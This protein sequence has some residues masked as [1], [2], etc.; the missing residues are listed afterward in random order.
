MQ[1]VFSL[2]VLALAAIASSQAPANLYSPSRT[3]KDQG[4]SLVGWGSGT[5]AE[6]DETAYEGASSLRVSTRNYFQGGIMNYA[7]P[8]NLAGAFQDSNNLLMFTVRIADAS[9]TMGGG[10]G[11][12][13]DLGSSS[14][15]GGG[16]GGGAVGRAGGVS[17]GGDPT[18][19]T[20]PVKLDK[21]RVILT[22]SDSKKSEAYLPLSTSSADAKGWIRVGVPL[23]AIAG[24][25]STNQ[26]VKSVAVSANA[27]GSVYV[28]EIRILNDATPIYGELL[29][30]DMNIG[31][32][33]AVNLTASGQAGAS[34]LKYTWS[35]QS[36]DE[37]TFSFEGQN[38][39]YRF[40]KPGT[41]RVSVTISDTNGLKKPYTTGSAVI[42]VN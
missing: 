39:A 1:K 29:V 11:G 12:G 4:I 7:A 34:I 40:R 33:T 36:A 8:V 26:M 9:M 18:S 13:G 2:S 28:G 21:I 42:T 5:I 35:I 19:G 15:S 24:F 25:A 37:P 20:G 27:P 41:Y 6:T 22:T 32:G 31:S 30:G 38:I 17:G 16:G 3:V 14:M 10:A 23:K